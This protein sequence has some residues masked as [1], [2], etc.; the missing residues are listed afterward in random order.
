[1]KLLA[2]FKKITFSSWFLACIPAILIIFFLPP[3]GS[4]F[5]LQVEPRFKTYSSYVFA[6]LNSDSISEI[7]HSGKG[8]PY[9]HIMVQDNNMKVYDQW[10]FQ[11]STDSD[12]STF[13]IGN[14]DNDRYKEIYI[15]TY[16]D[17]SLFLNIN[18]FFESGGYR[19]D[20]YY[21]TKIGV[22]NNKVTSTVSPAG[23]YDTNGD[24]K[25]ELF[26]SI[27]TGFGRQPRR[28]Y[29]I[30]LVNKSLNMSQLAGVVCQY[31]KMVDA[32]GDGRPEIFGLI[33]AS[34]NYNTWV[35]F[36]DWSTWLM[37]FDDKLRYKFPPVE[38]PG[39]T[40]ILDIN[41]YTNDSIKGYL[42][43][44]NTG[45]A[46]TAVLKPRIMLY[47]PNGTK[48]RERLFS[49]LNLSMH[50]FVVVIKNGDSDRIFLLSND[51]LELDKNFAVIKK[52][53]S[54][55]NSSY[56]FYTTD[57]DFDGKK[58]LFLYSVSEENL[59]IYNTELKKLAETKL[60][61]DDKKFRFSQY[62]STDH[63]NKIFVNAGENSYFLKLKKN[64]YY[65]LA[66]FVFPG[67][68]LMSFMFIQLIKRINTYQVIQKESLNRR[69]LTLQLQGIKSQLDPH[70]TFN[71]LNSVASLI[72][73]EDRQTAYDYMIKFTQ[74]L[75]SMLN[76]ADRIYRPLAEEIEFVTTYLELEKLRFG[77]KLDYHIDIGEKVNQREQVPKFVLQTFAEN[78][79]KHGL[80]TRSDGGILN[81]RVEKESYYLKLTIEDNGIGRE[82]SAGKSTSTGMGLKITS[83]FYD[84]LNQMNKK[85]IK[86]FVTDLFNET[87]EAIGTRVEVW[88]PVL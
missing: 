28:L 52:I 16:K 73:L 72:Y 27:Q 40:N 6:D 69:L 42:V 47:S 21:I 64:N 84:I 66:Y 22:V 20:R 81:I 87:G 56:E 49:D 8:V 46:D 77:D 50:G 63:E 23:F 44:H 35:P 14:F 2:L 1:M 9:F 24:G 80:M 83:E 13:F 76:D 54:P 18:E 41:S 33:G 58:E 79:I 70:F 3:I 31:P 75:R 67:I 4:R 85:P 86:H 88:I 25:K 45:S 10:N 68:Y 15:F 19:L 36:S 38:F 43:T 55:F 59:V 7:V 74:L 53:R 5:R 51:I 48:I 78:A 61:A 17:D 29:S 34:G 62:S 37:V 71:T 11:D 82:N 26:F 30:D 57:L 65:Y 60:K 12:L 32:D 39:F